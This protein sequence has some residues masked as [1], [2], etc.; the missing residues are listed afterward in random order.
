LRR[1]FEVV[2]L[3]L[4]VLVG[5]VSI[6]NGLEAHHHSLKVAISFVSLAISGAAWYAAARGF[7]TADAAGNDLA[8]T[9]TN[10]ARA[11]T[12]AAA[13]NTRTRSFLNAIAALAAITAIAFS[14]APLPTLKDF[15]G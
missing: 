9:N 8:F 14:V 11:D 13:F 10:V 4:L 6:S 7:D 15:L 12:V 2:L 3:S 5:T 1:W